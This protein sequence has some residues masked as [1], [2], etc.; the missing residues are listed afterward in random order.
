MVVGGG[1]SS[2]PWWSS[3][4]LTSILTLPEASLSM[5]NMKHNLSS[6]EDATGTDSGLQDDSLLPFLLN[7]EFESGRNYSS[8]T[9]LVNKSGGVSTPGDIGAIISYSS[10]TFVFIYCILFVTGAVGNLSVFLSVGHELRKTS[11]RSRIKVLILHL[12]MADLFVIFFV[13]PI[14]VFWRLTIFWYGGDTLCKICQFFRAFGLFLSSNVI[15]CI[16]LDRF[17]VII[18]PLKAIGGMRRVKNMLFFAWMAAVLF[19]APQV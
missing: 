2:S 16:S 19:A 8:V 1:T 11:R 9:D 14:E 6:L 13:I 15:I 7:G 5:E 10:M 12:S 18:S 3:V 17:Y 4:N